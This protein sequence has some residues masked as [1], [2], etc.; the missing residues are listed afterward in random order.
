[1]Q[2]FSEKRHKK[3][4]YCQGKFDEEHIDRTMVAIIIAKTN[5]H[6]YEYIKSPLKKMP[7]RLR[8]SS[9]R[10]KMPRTSGRSKKQRFI[11]GDNIYGKY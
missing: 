11:I 4:G 8:S 10:V 3:K 7:I 9:A 5:A 1:M 2:L 6:P